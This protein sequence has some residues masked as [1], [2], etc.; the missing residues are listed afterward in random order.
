MFA[1]RF[2]A[3]VVSVDRL[4]PTVLRLRFEP[5]SRLPFEAGQFVSLEVPTPRGPVFR[6]YSLA[7]GEGGVYELC[8]KLYSDGVGSRYVETLRPGDRIAASGSYGHFFYH[9]PELG[10]YVCF[11]GTGTGLAPLKAMVESR[12]FARHRPSDAILIQGARTEADLLYKGVFE[13]A[14]LREVIALSRPGAEWSGFK[15]RVT[16]Y[17]LSLPAGW[18]WHEIDFYL[19]GNS[20]MVLDTE[21]LLVHGRGVSRK[22]VF[23]EIFQPSSGLVTSASS[24]LP[25]RKTS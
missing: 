10:R 6:P 17:L 20:G 11:I 24:V 18:P 8:I 16:D 15:G 14:G 22:A 12:E 23:H 9:R 13:R 1:R 19:C 5:S 3:R 4:S 25:F 2:Q 7:G 21:R